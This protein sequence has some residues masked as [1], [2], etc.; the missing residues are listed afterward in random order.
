MKSRRALLST[1]A[2]G[3]AVLCVVF[4]YTLVAQVMEAP[5]GFDNLTNG[6]VSQATHDADRAIFEQVRTQAAG[7]GPTYNRTNC[8]ECHISPVSGGVSTFADLLAGSNAGGPFVARL[9]HENAIC[10]AAQDPPPGPT[11]ITTR[12]LTLN[13]LGDG[14]VESLADSTFTQIQ[15]SQPASMRGTILLVPV[16]V[17]ATAVGRF[18][19]KDPH[20]SLQAMA[21]NQ[22]RD[23]IGITNPLFPNELTAT[24]D[25][26]PDPEDT[27][28]DFD[29]AAR[30]IRATKAPPRDAALAGT[31]AAVAGGNLF[32][33]IGCNV[34]HVTS[35][36]TAPP[37]TVLQGGTLV[38]PAALGNKIIH[39][40]SDFLLHNLGTGDGFPATPKKMRTAPLWGLRTHQ[41]FLHDGASVSLRDAILRHAGEATTVIQNYN[42]LSTTQ[43]NQLFTFLQSL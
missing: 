20:V 1:L 35:L 22:F 43:K 39:P 14:Y 41:V 18:G 10:V 15:A 21:A 32:N 5:T 3:V 29:A 34:C 24:C 6:L 9:V 42:A 37:G 28:N 27:T 17:G 19:W 13:T 33:A 38:V 16:G 23:E 2:F 40:Y 36:T 4:S 26:V 25:T 30:F 31:P 8:A 7:L 12:R 11:E